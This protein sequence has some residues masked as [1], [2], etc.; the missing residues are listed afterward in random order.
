MFV[1]C[2]DLA[3]ATWIAASDEHWWNL[4][5]LGPPGFP[6]YARLRFIPDPVHEDQSENDAERRADAPS[7]NDQ[8]R[9]AVATLLQP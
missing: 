4:V 9:I 2:S 8:L 3:P 5:T 1:P 7:D 6:A